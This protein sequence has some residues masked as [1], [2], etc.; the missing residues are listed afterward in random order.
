LLEEEELQPLAVNL[1]K[2]WE[3]FEQE[4]ENCIKNLKA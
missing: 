3:Q 1:P 4:I 2:L